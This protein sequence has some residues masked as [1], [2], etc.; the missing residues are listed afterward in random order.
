MLMTFVPER[1]SM[2]ARPAY[3]GYLGAGR[4]R[5]EEERETRRKKRRKWLRRSATTV[6]TQTSARAGMATFSRRTQWRL[7]IVALLL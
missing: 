4:D 5:K 3:R 7:C 2:A 1:L 6:V